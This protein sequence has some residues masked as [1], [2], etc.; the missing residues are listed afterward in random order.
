ML[1]KQKATFNIIPSLQISTSSLDVD[2]SGKNLDAKYQVQRPYTIQEF[3]FQMRMDLDSSGPCY[4]F[5]QK[6]YIRCEFSWNPVLVIRDGN[7]NDLDLVDEMIQK[8]IS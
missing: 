8:D 1:I 3:Y 5:N 4:Y 7:R 6:V 2:L